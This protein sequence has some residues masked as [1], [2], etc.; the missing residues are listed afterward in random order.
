MSLSQFAINNA[1]PQDKPYLL[2]DGDGLHLRIHPKGG[3][4]WR[5]RFRFGGKANMMS[6]GPYPAV[7]LLQARRKRDRVKEQLAAGINPSLSQEARKAGQLSR[8]SK[9]VRRCSR[10][11]PCQF[12]EERCGR[13]D[14]Q[15]KSL[16]V[17]RP[18][19]PNPEPPYR[20]DKT[21]RSTRHPQE[22]R[23]KRPDGIPPIACAPLSE[24]SSA[25]PSRPSAQRPILPIP[26]AV[27]S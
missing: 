24:P 4:Q 3:R 17:A 25:M 13:T 23:N 27:R 16:D 9:H 20:R 11:V 19:C 18:G 2:S 15:Q 7:S 14:P 26:F 6:L 12:E 21:C 22:D 10:R 1:K 5:L 8:R